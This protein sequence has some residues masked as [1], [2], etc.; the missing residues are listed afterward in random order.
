MTHAIVREE[1]VVIV[2]AIGEIDLSRALMLKAEAFRE[3][4]A[5]PTR[6]VLYDIRFA[7]LALDQGACD[8]LYEATVRW[9]FT[10]CATNAIVV[11]EFSFQPFLA[12]ASRYAASGV[13]NAVFTDHA[14]ALQWAKEHPLPA[15]TRRVA[16]L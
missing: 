10:R 9:G 12:H 15:S 7:R 16:R 8:L 2:T 6:A 11:P 1:G 5:K 13:C 4:T 3:W 14:C